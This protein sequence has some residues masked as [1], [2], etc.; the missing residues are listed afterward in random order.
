MRL[1]DNPSVEKLAEDFDNDVQFINS[2]FEF[3]KDIKWIEQDDLSDLYQMT[4]VGKVKANISTV[5]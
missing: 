1:V 3:L 2:I 5:H 4:E